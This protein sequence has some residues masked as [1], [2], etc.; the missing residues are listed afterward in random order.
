ML[1]KYVTYRANTLKPD[2]NKKFHV[3]KKGTK[4]EGK[5]NNNNNYY[6]YC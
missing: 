4:K 5:H 6:N 1:Q 2:A 3:I